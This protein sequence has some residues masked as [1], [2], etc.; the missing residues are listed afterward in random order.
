MSRTCAGPR[1]THGRG[2]TP[3]H[4]LH[5]STSCDWQ[6]P[7][8]PPP[9]GGI[10]CTSSTHGQ[11]TTPYVPISE[12][13]TMVRC[14]DL[15][16]LSGFSVNCFTWLYVF[17]DQPFLSAWS[18]GGPVA[19]VYGGLFAIAGTGLVTLSL[20][21]VASACPSIGG[22]CWANGLLVRE[23]RLRVQPVR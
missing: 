8:P 6:A 15:F 7:L 4:T 19:I 12:H 13:R 5:Q 14:L 10:E 3:P 9:G 1:T 20:A 16:Q 17:T 23:R 2:H 18:N 22:G 11:G 21:E